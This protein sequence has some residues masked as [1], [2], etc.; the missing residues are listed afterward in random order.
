MKKRLHFRPSHRDKAERHIITAG[1]SVGASV[2]QLNGT[3]L[4]DLLVGYKGVTFLPE[5]KTRGLET[6]DKRNGKT[7][8]RTTRVSEGQK[9]FAEKW[10]GG[11][12]GIVYEPKDLLVM[13][14]APSILTSGPVQVRR[15][16]AENGAY[17]CESC[18][19][20]ENGLHAKDC[21]TRKALARPPKV[22]TA[23]RA[24]KKAR[25]L[26]PRRAPEEMQTLAPVLSA[27][28]PPDWMAEAVREHHEELR[29]SRGVE[30]E[31]QPLKVK[32]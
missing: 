6:T 10:R 1:R 16:L 7:Y 28:L 17:L 22:E 25:D 23:H 24:A 2:E 26:L 32:P 4:P 5:V 31:L 19:L 12:T 8:K 30:G 27:P 14:G 21:P 20:P 13:I 9:T 29:K 11:P 3:D 18:W 15:W